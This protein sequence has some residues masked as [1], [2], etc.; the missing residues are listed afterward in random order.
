MRITDKS[1]AMYLLKSN[2]FPPYEIPNLK[3]ALAMSYLIT[4]KI[5]LPIFT[6]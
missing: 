2:D 3:Q 5:N 4:H 1:S 6:K